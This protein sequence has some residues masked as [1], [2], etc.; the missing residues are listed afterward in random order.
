MKLT[1]DLNWR[2][3]LR[4][5]IGAIL[6]WAALSKVANLQSFLGAL[7]SYQLPLP[8][9]SVRLVVKALPWL[10]LLCGLSLIGGHLCR[11]AL[12][13]SALLFS[14][15]VLATGQAWWRGLDINCGCLNLELLGVPIDS[16]IARLLSGPIFAFSRALLLLGAA[17]ALWRLTPR[18][19]GEG[20]ELVGQRTA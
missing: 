19:S 11:P 2:L 15:F 1:L 9:W 6:I 20:T 14:V 18:N 10:E 5:F 13:W 12:A 3:T 7:M 4:W 17:L 16:S 8:G